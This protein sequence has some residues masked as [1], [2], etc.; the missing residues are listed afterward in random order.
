VQG[1]LPADAA[2]L[3]AEKG[4]QGLRFGTVVH[5]VLTAWDFRD[6]S[7]A[8]MLARVLTGLGLVDGE[9]RQ[10][11]GA[12]AKRQILSARSAG[13]FDDIA[14]SAERMS[15]F[16]VAARLDDFVIEGVIDSVH[17][18]DDGTWEIVDY[19]TDRVAPD[20]MAELAAHYEP[21]LACYAAAFSRSGL[22]LS[23]VSLLF[24]RAGRRHTWKCDSSRLEAWERMLRSCV[25]GVRSGRFEDAREQPCRCGYCGWLCDRSKAGTGDLELA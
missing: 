2:T 13:V 17:R 14:S 8:S 6:D 18:L 15:E 3:A 10:A 24:L 20:G 11:V 5:R 16:P 12:E 7:L 19:K 9:E 22:P 23:R 1:I 21:Q 25:E 4:S